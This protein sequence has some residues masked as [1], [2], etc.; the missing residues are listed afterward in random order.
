MAI[1]RVEDIY[2][3]SIQQIV[4]ESYLEEADLFDDEGYL[5]RKLLLGT[6]RPGYSNADIPDLG[7]PD[8]NQGWPGY[9]RLTQ[10]QIDE[11]LANYTVIHQWSDNP[12]TGPVAGSR[13]APD[14]EHT[15]GLILNG[16]AMLANTGFSATLIQKKDSNEYTLSI[17]STESRA[18]EHG[19]DSERDMEAT[20]KFGVVMTGFA[21][22]QLDAMELYYQWLK[23]NGLLPQGAV[24]NVTGYSLGGHLATV[25]TEMHQDDPWLERFGETVTFNGAGRGTW[26]GSIGT[27]A[28]FLAYYRQVLH[29]PASAGID[30]STCSESSL[31]HAVA[32]SA[33]AGF[34]L[35]LEVDVLFGA[36][37][38][39]AGLQEAA[40]ACGDAAFD[41][42]SVYDDSRYG[43]AV[44]AT[45]LKFGIAPQLPGAE[46]STLADDEITQVYGY[47]AINNM[48]MTANSQN[49]GM[50][51]AIA[52]ES[53]PLLDGLGGFIGSGDY[54]FGHSIALITDSL[55]LQRSIETLDAGFESNRF[56]GWMP[57]YSAMDT[58]NVIG[59]N[60]EADPLE[61][62]LDGM[63]R[64]LLGPGVEATPYR[65]GAGGFGDWDS[66]NAFHLN[67]DAL[68][69]SDAFQA[70][71]GKVEFCL[72]DAAVDARADFSAFAGLFALSPVYLRAVAGQEETVEAALATSWG[73]VHEEWATDREEATALY[74]A[75]SWYEDRSSLL[76]WW[77]NANGENAGDGLLRDPV[78]R[79]G[80]AYL[81]LE[82]E[83]TLTVRAAEGDDLRRHVIFDRAEPTFALEGG[84]G[85]DSLYAGRGGSHL[86]GAAGDDLLAGLGGADT[87]EGGD[88]RDVLQGMAGDDVLDG[89]LGADRLEGGLGNDS[90]RLR[91][92]DGVDT[93]VDADG[94]GSILVDG[95]PLTGGARL[96]EATWR[97]GDG[98]F[99]LVLGTDA[100]G[101]PLL[102][103][104]PIGG[105]RGGEVSL[106]YIQGFSSGDFGIDLPGAV[107][108]PPPPGGPILGDVDPIRVSYVAANGLTY[109]GY[110]WD[111]L[112]NLVGTPEQRPG[113][114]MLFGGGEADEIRGLEGN[115]TLFG[116][117][118]A[119]ALAGGAGSDLLAGGSGDDTLEAGDG[120]D[121]LYGDANP[122]Q[123][124]A[125]AGTEVVPATTPPPLAQAVYVDAGIGW[126]RYKVDTTDLPPSSQSN[127]DAVTPVL[128]Q[129]SPARFG[130]SVLLQAD[131]S[132]PGQGIGGDDLLLAGA[133]DDLLSGQAGND[134]LEGGAGHDR[135]TGGGG[136]DLLLGGADDD[137]LF[138]DGLVYAAFRWSSLDLAGEY[139]VTDREEAYADE[140]GNDTLVG[141]EGADYL[142]GMAG[143]D[144]LLGGGG[145][146]FLVGDFQEVIAL[147]VLR[148]AD[149]GTVFM[150][151][152]LHF[153]EAVRHHGNDFL[154]G[155]ADDDVLIGLAGDDELLGG[156]G[157]DVL[158]AD[159]NAAE[160]QGQYGDDRLDGGNGN[161]LLFGSGGD[162]LLDGG[163][164]D[165]ELWG[166]EYAGTDGVAVGAWGDAPLPGGA[167][168]GGLP[169]SLHGRDEIRGGEGADTLIGGGLSDW[170]DGG[171]GNDVIFGDG[172]GVEQ[173]GDDELL[174][175]DGDDE[176]QGN[177]GQDLLR[178]EA[179]NDR[180][181][182]QAGADRL[183]GATG[184]DYLDGGAEADVLEGGTGADVL[185]G[186]EG[187]DALSGGE[188]HDQLMGGLGDDVLDGGFGRDYLNGGDG[189]DRYRLRAGDS[190]VAAGGYE[191]IDDRVGDNLVVIE[192]VASSALRLQRTA[193]AG[194][195][196]LRFGADDGVVVR[197][198]MQ[199]AVS[200]YGLADGE[201]AWD[202]LMTTLLEDA[203]VAQPANGAYAVG[204]KAAD[205]FVLGS[206]TRLRAGLGDDVVT[207]GGAGNTLLVNT[208][209]GM[210]RIAS[211]PGSLAGANTVQFGAGLALADLALTLRRVDA[212]APV[213]L[214]EL[215]FGGGDGV[216]LQVDIADVYGSAPLRWFAFDDGTVLSLEELV[217]RQG[218][219][220]PGSAGAD[221]LQ[222]SNLAEHIA[223]GEGNDQL[224]GNAGDDWLQGDAGDDR[225]SGGAGADR[226]V[227]ANGQGDDR[228]N[229]QGVTGE[230]DV[231]VF[232]EGITPDAVAFGHDGH[233]LTLRVRW[234]AGS[235]VI[236]GQVD[237][238]AQRI[239]SF[240]FADGTVWSHDDVM[241][242]AIT[243]PLPV[244]RLGGDKADNLTGDV[245]DDYLAGLAGDDT[246]AGG[247]GHDELWGGAGTDTLRGGAGND[248]LEG[249]A[250]NDYLYGGDGDDLLVGGADRD[251]LK[252]EAGNDR[253]L[254]DDG[255]DSL[256]GGTGDDLLLAGDGNDWL[257]GDEGNDELQGGSGDDDLY[258]R[259]GDDRLL[260]GD[261]NDRLQGGAGDD[262]LDGGAGDDSMLS[263]G[264]GNDVI[265]GGAGADVL[266]GNAGH[267]RLAGGDGNDVLDSGDGDDE[268]LGGAGDDELHVGD[269]ADAVDAGAGND[270]I[271]VTMWQTDAGMDR[272][273]GGDGDDTYLLEFSWGNAPLVIV[274]T[275]DG[276]RDTVVSYADHVLSDHVE[277]LVL[278]GFD[279]MRALNGTGNAGDNILTGNE[280]A[281]VLRGGAGNDTFIAGAGDTV[282]ELAG[283]GQDTVKAGTDWVLG[284]NVEDL[285]LEG[286]ALTGTGNA[287]DN[288][289]IG[290]AGANRLDGGA[291]ADHLEG[292][293]GDD[294]YWIDESG[295]V[296]VEV[297][298]GGYDLVYSSVSIPLLADHVEDVVLTGRGRIN[299][300]GNALDNRLTGNRGANVMA[301]GDGDDYYEVGARDTVVELAGGGV[302]TVAAS[303]SWT[304]GQF[305]EQLLLT[306]DRRIS[307]AGNAQANTLRGNVATNT[308][309]GGAGDDTYCFGRGGGAD[310]VVDND[311]TAGN[312]DILRFDPGIALEQLWFQRSGSDLE[313]SVIGT[314]DSVT[315]GDWFAGAEHRVERI[316]VAD[317]HLL[318]DS[319]VDALVQA[320]AAMAPP[321]LG[322]E[323]LTAAQ[324][325][326][327]EPVLASSWQLA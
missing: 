215:R 123:A 196:A 20:D 301:G 206:D 185:F 246:L 187:D 204:G 3:F 235:L 152:S 121:I 44:V 293:Q 298:E 319:Q 254:G 243:G 270:R 132:H 205:S 119:D 266:E 97:S 138:G 141:G 218:L 61:N 2:E 302:D 117:D 159:G 19:G 309:S 294:T 13:P 156:D 79:E 233:D 154:D 49:N 48:N 140:Y 90:Y 175:G 30:F 148:L 6:N 284:A 27:E 157:K 115:D 93:I 292:G 229:E 291:G 69:Q 113:A 108:A 269:G 17:R 171:A 111:A 192:G 169:S 107:V 228:I 278:E 9:T 1:E 53:Q 277:N 207:L 46:H 297:A 262:V 120:N 178:G 304:L 153:E 91:S 310:H 237:Q 23:D 151:T 10:P 59:T 182:G 189:N 7:N 96:S 25:F 126:I 33:A 162:D 135:L 35:D 38:G 42:V 21:L 314:E 287:D 133:G 36:A 255:V 22:A 220:V 131:V 232:G 89:G 24:L 324:Y 52:V 176:L 217:T 15:G 66:R 31:Q 209:D 308:L 100:E 214:L 271:L 230:A 129:L 170:L 64:V 32:W 186:G 127:P 149:D 116:R 164:G 142:F 234:Q 177:G 109:D 105:N 26:N 276:G 313:V 104:A 290:T 289:I 74:F 12:S 195:L 87:L 122:F 231:L 172:I 94:A 146:D 45:M 265:E 212:A 155:G 34:A 224:W 58:Q 221:L 137:L 106:L 307:G 73:D 216:A 43:W 272:L 306:G 285:V 325:Q 167:G 327:L 54:G 16:P 125:Q 95:Q 258:G 259:A 312:A 213:D 200:R 288:R 198:G 275:A 158:I 11:F 188:D 5:A 296:I 28:D 70:V 110:Q 282:V 184:D 267:D 193:T 180:L 76:Q 118:G 315:V 323:D 311:A 62:V 252:G 85:R 130:E 88:G 194:D 18:W 299:V 8:L 72:P 114:D 248:R 240:Q 145:A 165:D 303:V 295:D 256:Q 68:C 263:G 86:L 253:L 260:A 161:D 320:M 223:G 318:L 316:V 241:A 80:V 321:P 300:T 166:D 279:G 75:D 103:V 112:G 250:G 60:Y 280:A 134:Q 191:T 98:R 67:L 71:T 168:S 143:A 174:G 249:E 305:E 211:A 222:G 273:A 242:R 283:E 219:T 124:N 29:D 274:E 202:D 197:G 245:G 65:E 322:Q 225:L 82:T 102:Q 83:L 81:D 261:G 101:S 286:A 281:N 128:L 14:L 47:E 163:A 236:A 183:A 238:A 55:A 84:T 39:L 92:G 251:F 239:E 77:L 40:L 144:I 136:S 210:D 226:Y 179:G 257:S 326:Q 139:R 56:L 37:S 268:L 147:P 317:G 63:R 50:E 201:F 57:L 99:R 181:F 199:G 244:Y 150:D 78:G 190:P 4:A 51:W 247:A 203:V 173:E 264:D 208:G 227:Y 160:V 41:P